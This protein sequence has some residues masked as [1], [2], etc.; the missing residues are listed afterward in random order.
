ML[1]GPDVYLDALEKSLGV[2]GHG[3]G[4]VRE[5][6]AQVIEFVD[7]HLTSWGQCRRIVALFDTIASGYPA[8][9][10]IDAFTL[11]IDRYC[12]GI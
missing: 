12:R 1:Q 9:F 4:F 8:V 3:D 2:D 7:L 6:V 5:C 10:S 11:W